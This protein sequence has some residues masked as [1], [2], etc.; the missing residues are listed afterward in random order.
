MASNQTSRRARWRRWSITLW[1]AL[2][3]AIGAQF[4]QPAEP[5]SA[6]NLMSCCPFA[7]QQAP[8]LVAAV[9]PQHTYD[10]SPWFTKAL[11][12]GFNAW[13]DTGTGAF[14]SMEFVADANAQIMYWTDTNPADG[15]S[16][17][18]CQAGTRTASASG[19]S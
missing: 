16:S 18:G 12:G 5:V 7:R 1:A 19:H 13:N 2:L 9:W 10:N 4:V 17:G 14:V 15:P 8:R 6:Y 11:I 3:P